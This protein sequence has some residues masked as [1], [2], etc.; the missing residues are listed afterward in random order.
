[1]LPLWILKICRCLLSWGTLGVCRP[2]M[3]GPKKVK[4]VVFSEV[5]MQERTYFIIGFQV[6]HQLW[7]GGLWLQRRAAGYL[8]AVIQFPLLQ[9]TAVCSVLGVNDHLHLELCSQHGLCNGLLLLLDTVN[10]CL[11]GKANANEIIV[12]IKCLS[13]NKS[14]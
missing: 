8:C 9:G 7:Q 6:K 13:L 14:Q 3:Y 5:K 10:L 4:Y 1:M 12:V 11:D 2:C